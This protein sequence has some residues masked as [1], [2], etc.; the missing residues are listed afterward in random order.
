VYSIP[1][2]RKI[3]MAYSVKHELFRSIFTRLQSDVLRRE[4]FLPPAQHQTQLNQDIFGL[5]VNRFKAGFFIEI[6]AN[7]GFTFSN[8]VYLENHFGWDGLLIEANPRYKKSLMQRKARAVML[9]ILSEKGTVD[10][11]DAGLYGG[12]DQ[13]LD[14]TNPGATDGCEVI[15]VPGERLL[16]VLENFKAPKL[17]DF[18]T[19]DVEGGE[20]AIVK[21]LCELEEFRFKCGCIEHNFRVDDYRSM[22]SLLEHAGY[23]IVWE[24]Q[25]HHD[26]FFVD[27]S[28]TL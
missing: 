5:L 17:I 19:I 21:Q 4:L 27:V 22:K 13:T 3:S 2:F 9:A 15:T 23:Q 14:K 12:V 6:G 20:L 18:I 8:T 11:R 7:D 16:S 26:L 10:F 25:T 1:L 28:H 24:G